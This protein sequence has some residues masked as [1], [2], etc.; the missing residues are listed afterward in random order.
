MPILDFHGFCKG[1]KNHT[2]KSNCDTSW[3]WN[4]IE[5]SKGVEAY[6]PDS[7]FIYLEEVLEYTRTFDALAEGCQNN[8][9]KASVHAHLGRLHSRYFRDLSLAKAHSDTAIAMVKAIDPLAP[10]QSRLVNHCLSIGYANLGRVCYWEGD[11]ACATENFNKA[12]TFIDQSTDADEAAKLY[13]NIGVVHLQQSDFVN[14]VTY[15]FAAQRLF[16]QVGDSVGIAG[17]LVNLGAVSHTIGVYEIALDNYQSA[18]SIYEEKNQLQQKASTLINIGDVFINAKTPEKSP[19]YYHRAK[20][21]YEFLGDNSG[22]A[23]AH[24]CIGTSHIH[25]RNLDCAQHSLDTA[26]QLFQLVGERLGLGGVYESYG[27][28]YQLKGDYQSAKAHLLKSMDYYLESEMQ[29]HVATLH[30]KL[31]E[32]YIELNQ[33]GKAQ[34]SAEQS[35]RE[36]NNLGVKAVQRDAYRILSQVMYKRGRYR[37]AYLLHRNFFT[38]HDSLLSAEKTHRFAQIEAVYRL[39]EKEKT[40]AELEKQSALREADL[41]RAKVSMYRQRNQLYMASGVIV[42][43]LITLAFFYSRYQIKERANRML[44]VQFAEISQKNEEIL[45]QNEEI[46]FQR[47][48]ME[49]HKNLL[50]EKNEELEHFNWLMSQSVVYASNIQMGLMPTNEQLKEYFSDVFTIF[51]P[52]DVVSGD[53]Y[54]AFAK[55]NSIVL[56]LGDCTGH[57]VPGGFMS[58]LGITALTELMGRNLTNPAEILDNL[59]LLVIQSLNQTGKIGEQQDGMDLSIIRYVKGSGV[60]E[61][62]GANHPIWF[63]RPLPNNPNNCTL[64]IVKGDSMPI[65]Y[66]H[67]MT[68]F[69]T[70]TIEVSPGDMFYLFSDGFRDQLGGDKL[71]SKLGIRQ[72]RKLISENASLP[73][74]DQ[75][76]YLENTFF[77][78]ASGNDQ[79]DDITIMGLKI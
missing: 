65:S 41:S 12:L 23:T 31:A 13:N 27:E 46:Y 76:N 17:I 3:V 56:A 43:G 29:S 26:L 22:V 1:E 6:Y 57:G 45:S 72:F 35:L 7:A 67:K 34:Q 5:R 79:V 51:Y 48:E 50:K 73:L 32:V 61:F 4:Q 19:P 11:F 68:P 55:D 63:A 16:I 36:A 38:L 77:V 58:M 47:S 42:I 24:L 14:A 40:I 21:I 69:T 28:L 18:L 30:A 64:E 44:K 54:W 39:G 9:L 74:D 78:W 71:N 37:E 53:F 70:H 25:S 10:S 60:I 75:K 15:L 8:I 2:T 49:R 33:L 59:R 62:A 52:K 20:D 66:H